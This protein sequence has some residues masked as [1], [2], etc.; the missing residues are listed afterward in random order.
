MTAWL[1]AG[2]GIDALV[3]ATLP[4]PEP[5]EHE[6]L[7]RVLARS[8]N[9]R[10]LLV[11]GG[12]DGWRP[13]SAIV[14]VSDAVGEVV[15]RGAGV[16]R[17]AVGARA[18]AIF[19]PHWRTSRLTAQTYVDPVGG[20]VTRGMLAEY[21]VIDEQEAVAA[22]RTLS[23]AE[24]ATLP[25][26]GV[27]AW[28]AVVVR[29]AV[30]ASNTV[31]VHGTGGVSLFALQFARAHGAR[32]A[33]TSSSEDKL[34]RARALGA[35]LTVNYRTQDVA[36]AILEWTGGD[37][38]DLVVDTVG[39]E[40]LNLSLRAVRIGGRIAF[41]GLIAG[42]AAQ[43][44]TYEFVTRNVSVEG[45]ETGSREMYERMAEFIDAHDIHPVIDSVSAS[46]D[47]RDALHRLQAGG[48]FGKLVLI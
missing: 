46:G 40:N 23:D 6:L 7:V 25:I 17:F 14:P 35:E 48:A 4:V 3:P 19:L 33:I 41:I 39:G 30:A 27:T 37:G 10:D 13:A 11:I 21:V 18:S 24:A 29:G 45:I 1:T 31:L 2:D 5:G 43:V 16:T 26:A 22:P 42:R 20:P 15:A 12:R 38:A 36:G 32:V 47:V 9:H 28:H 44:N 34:Q 8:L